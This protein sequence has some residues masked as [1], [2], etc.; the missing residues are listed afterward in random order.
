MRIDAGLVLDRLHA[1]TAVSRRPEDSLHS[2]EASS[3]QSDVADGFSPTSKAAL[4]ELAEGL[5]WIWICLGKDSGLPA[6]TAALEVCA[7]HGVSL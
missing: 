1:T 3:A 2:S 6:E 7:D 5:R 4:S